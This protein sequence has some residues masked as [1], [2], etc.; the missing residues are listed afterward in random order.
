MVGAGLAE[1]MRVAILQ[2]LKT[3]RYN[4]THAARELGLSLPTLRKR[5]RALGIR[6]PERGEPDAR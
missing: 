2:A 3:H 1:A 5:M 4:R 6:V